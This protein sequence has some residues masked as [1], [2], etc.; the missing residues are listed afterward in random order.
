MIGILNNFLAIIWDVSPE[1]VDGWRTPNYYGLLFV[2][3]LILGYFVMRRMYR[4]ANMSDE[5][6]DKLVLYV[7][8][9]TIVGARLGHVIFYGPHWGPDGYFSHPLDI[10]KVWE[11]GLASHGGVIA[12]LIA[13]YIYSKR[14]I[15]KPVVW[16]LDRMVA[17]SAIAAAFIRFGNLMNSEIVGDPTNVP[18]AFEFVN[19]VNDMGYTDPTPRHPAQLYE[20][21]CYLFIFGLL[22]FLFWKKQ[23]WRKPGRLFGIF[24]VLLFS[25]RF[26]VEFVKVGQ[27][28][29][30][31]GLSINT[32]Q[33]LSV[34]FV[35]AGFY[36]I[37]R[38]YK[39]P[40][41]EE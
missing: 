10:F 8:I 41:V 35:L 5:L 12:L 27:S 28:A 31:E 29:Y 15:K 22:M 13:V 19:Y 4:K 37:Y 11:G 21:L 24:L 34:P 20:A 39:N 18:W 23:V 6:L 30:D 1:I 36:F 32:G 7:I 33:W 40:A 16:L 25:A 38:S 17:P 9:A 26:F 14:V 2:T 3:G